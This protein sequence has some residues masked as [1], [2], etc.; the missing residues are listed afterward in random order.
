MYPHERS[1]VQRL[2]NRPFALIGVNSDPL[3]KAHEALERETITWRSFFNGGSTQGPISQAWGVTAWPTIY[4]LDDRGVIRYKNVR[5]EDMDKA[6]DELIERAVVTLVE[7]VKSEDP[8]VRGLAAFRMGRYDAP[9]AVATLVPLLEDSDVT[10]QQRTATGLALLGQPVEPLLPRIRPATSDVDPEVRIS[11]LGVLA[12]AK[13]AQSV[14][15][16]VQALE[17]ELA[18]VRVAAVKALGQLGDPAT[19]PALAKAVDD[20]EANIAREAA[21]ALAAMNAPESTE[22]LKVLATKRDHPARVWIAVAMHRV[23]PT[24][25]DARVKTLMADLDVAIRRQTT[26]ILPDLK[27]YDA[28]E[29]FITALEDADDQVS[30]SARTFLAKSQSPRAQEALKQFFVA[31]IDKLVPVLS[32]QDLNARRK[33]QTD[34]FALGPDVATMLMERLPSIEDVAAMSALAQVIGAMRNPDVLPAVIAQIKRP[35][36]EENRRAVLDSFV[37]YFPAQLS[38][39]AVELV[40]SNEPVVRLSGVRMLSMN[41][42]TRAREVLKSAL[43]DTDP[44]VRAYAAI[45]LSRLRDPD[46]LAVLKELATQSDRTLQQQAVFGMANYDEETVWPSILELLSSEDQAV[47][48]ITFSVLGRFKS[49]QVTA[50][51]VEKSAGDE[52]LRRQALSVLAQQGTADAARALGEFLKNTDPEVQRQ[53]EMW[54]QRLRIPEAQTILQ[55]FRKQQEEEK[56]KAESEKKKADG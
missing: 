5:G 11:S 22:L 13:D 1:L 38:A 40:K 8:A 51:I 37:R 41:P 36:L 53:A 52:V 20:K 33:A 54:L 30:K 17:D 35:D 50:V 45:G 23:D 32:E 3:E 48:A 4:V 43:P 47:R 15:L 49:P 7:N 25:T 34:L 56:A 44:R 46:A 19:A 10:V 24:D 55:E 6:V 16:A 14:P 26:S 31:R 29:I 28:T 2:E 18:A 9:D 42:D 27:D 12:A 39:E 21:Y